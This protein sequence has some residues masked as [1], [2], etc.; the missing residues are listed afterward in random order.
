MVASYA[1]KGY[2]PNPNATA[3]GAPSQTIY[4][5]LPT[6]FSEKQLIEFL[7]LFEG[8]EICKF[9][10]SFALARFSSVACAV[11]AFDQ[12]HH[13]T[14]ILIQYAKAKSNIYFGIFFL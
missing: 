1:Q 8:F 10:S 6:S 2:L 3:T 9:F 13:K 11:E 14:N 4:F 7:Q 12:I 5:V